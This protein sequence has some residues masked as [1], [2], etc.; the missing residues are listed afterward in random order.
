M[1]TVRKTEPWFW[2]GWRDQAGMSWHATLEGVYPKYLNKSFLL[3]LYLSRFLCCLLPH[4]SWSKILFVRRIKQTISENLV[5]LHTIKGEV[6]LSKGVLND[7]SKN[8]LKS[9][10][11]QIPSLHSLK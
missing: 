5:F 3:Q 2:R 4:V 6:G 8:G 1:I 7:V 11:K 9:I 10:H